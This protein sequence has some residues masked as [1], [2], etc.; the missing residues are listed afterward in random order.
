MADVSAMLPANVEREGF[1]TYSAAHHHGLIEIF[2]L[3]FL[4]PFMSSIFIYNQWSTYVLSQD[5]GFLELTKFWTQQARPQGHTCLPLIFYLLNLLK[6]E[7]VCVSFLS[8]YF[9]HSSGLPAAGLQGGRRRHHG[10]W[11]RASQTH[12]GWG[13]DPLP[14][15]E[16]GHDHRETETGAGE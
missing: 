16:V 11:E 9:S 4:A 6:W 5:I 15:S 8:L 14:H 10:V 13:G 12:H 7:S 2:W 3:L 1:M